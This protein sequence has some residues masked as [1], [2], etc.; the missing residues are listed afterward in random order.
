MTTPGALG[1]PPPAVR[2][3]KPGLDAPLTDTARLFV[4][5]FDPGVRT[6]WCVM[7]VS[8]AALRAGGL[9]GVALA[10][11]DPSVF[12]WA[13]GYIQGP[14]PWQAELM[15]ALCR[16]TWMHGFGEFKLGPE[17]DLFVCAIEKF[18]LRVMADD[19]ELLSPVR[20]PAAF[21]ALAWRAPFPMLWSP[22][23]DAM[24][25]FTDARLR[26]FNLW[27]GPAGLIGEHQRDATRHAALL[28]RKCVEPEWLEALEKRMPW[29]Q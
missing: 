27:S 11:P 29:L 6:G 23:P 10:N 8:L 4:V 12:A 9:R 19:A 7:R 21:G 20:V 14:E 25:V 15:M 17:S 18:Q 24:R 22:I 13:A 5:A 2:V 28:V 26:A 1:S 3:L 16:G